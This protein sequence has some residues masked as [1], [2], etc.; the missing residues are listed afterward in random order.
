MHIFPELHEAHRTIN[1]QWQ[2]SLLASHYV[3]LL[4]LCGITVFYG[5]ERVVKTARHDRATE[6]EGEAET[7]TG[8]P[9]FWLHIFSFGIYN[10][11][12][13]YL[14][15][16]REDQ[17]LRSLIFFTIAIGFHFLANDF[18]LADDHKETYHR[19]GR[20]VLAMAILI[21]WGLG[22][23]VTVDETILGALFAFLAGG[24]I[25]NVLKEELPEGRLSRFGPFALGAAI[26]SGLLV[27]A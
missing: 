7:R 8:L 13:A 9:V 25:L 6:N 20:W 5:L 12:I 26:Y 23:W 15:V 19:W 1:D 22:L 17:T 11:L 16:H 24:I 2:E 27:F 4:S 21:G 18:A 10:A 3:Y 14:L